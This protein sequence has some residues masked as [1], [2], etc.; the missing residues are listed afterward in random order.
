MS[1]KNGI[2]KV[3]MSNPAYE[4]ANDKA[5]PLA[6]CTSVSLDIIMLDNDN[7]E[8]FIEAL[9]LCLDN[10]RAR[11]KKDYYT[12][13]SDKDPNTIFIKQQQEFIQ[14]QAAAAVATS[15]PQPV[16]MVG[17]ASTTNEDQDSITI[18]DNLSKVKSQHTILCAMQVKCT[19]LTAGVKVLLSKLSPVLEGTLAS[20]GGHY[21]KASSYKEQLQTYMDK[22]SCNTQDFLQCMVKAPTI[23]QAF[24]TLILS[25]QVKTSSPSDDWETIATEANILMLKPPILGR[26]TTQRPA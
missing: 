11:N 18:G 17:R 19:V 8:L 1:G 21:E 6:G 25:C 15:S 22:C 12:M 10:V 23:V 26:K 14:V 16:Q 13:H 24:A 20:K 2:G 3:T 9:Q 5:I 4:P 7:D